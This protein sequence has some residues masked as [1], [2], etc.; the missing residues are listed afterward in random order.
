[1]APQ[2]SQIFVTWTKAGVTLDFP[3]ALDLRR[4]A[5]DRAWRIFTFAI[6]ILIC[7]LLWFAA[8]QVLQWPAYQGFSLLLFVLGIVGLIAAVTSSSRA[9]QY[10]ERDDDLRQLAVVDHLVIR[11]SRDQRKRFWYRPEIRAV[12]VDDVVIAND[13]Q[14]ESG[15]RLLAIREVRLLFELHNGERVLLFGRA[16]TD[17]AS[18]QMELEEIAEHLRH[19]LQTDAPPMTIGETS[20][21]SHAAALQVGY[22]Q[23]EGIRHCS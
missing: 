7:S 8:C 15:T 20:T 6:I 5:H 3:L 12:L 11:T 9:R 1:M 21:S 17:P 23:Q 22:P 10:A 14:S 16:V 4:L 2:H 18:D 13:R 19:A